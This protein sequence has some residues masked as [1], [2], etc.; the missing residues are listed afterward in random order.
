VPLA[1][2][3]AGTPEFAVPALEAIA[4]AGHTLL[5]VYTQPDRPAGRGRQLT[6]SPVKRRARELGLAVHQ[7]ATL[8]DAAATGSLAALAPDVMVVAAYGLLLPPA[9][10]A[11]PRLGCINIHASL[12]PRWRGAAPVQRA[13]IAGD[14]ETGVAIMRMEAG[15]DTG[16]VYKSERLAIGARETAASLT[17]RLAALGARLI[18]S[19]LADLEAGR[20]VAI[21]QGTEGVTYASKLTKHEALLDWSQPAEALERRV[22]AYLPWPVAET[23]FRGAQ[24]KVHAAELVPLAAGAPP[25]SIVTVD[26]DGLVV[27]TGAGRLRLTRLQA[28]G[29]GVV[30]AAEFAAAAARRAPLAGERLGG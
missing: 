20:A 3:Y 22:R 15:L 28:P 1:V 17:T 30:S 14:A 19:A 16:A 12:L 10:L 23:T 6:E 25:G 21:P 8:K 11:I 18:V 9:I 5:A 4:D 24:L 27:A 29:R 13:L 2:V 26:A 7:P